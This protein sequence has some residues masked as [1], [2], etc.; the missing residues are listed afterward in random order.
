[1]A[2]AED[3]WTGVE[4]VVAVGDVHGD[5]EALVSVLLSAGLIDSKNNWAGGQAHL[6]QLGD[7]PDRGADSRKA[8]DLLMTLEKQARRAR[9]YVH[10][11]IGNHEAMNVYGD[12]RYVSDGEYAAFAADESAEVQR[13]AA[14]AGHRPGYVEHRRQFSEEG[15]YG[16]WIRGHNAIIRI[17]DT[18]FVH[19]GISEKY[20]GLSIRAINDRVREEL[21]DFSKLRGGI[22]TDPE[23]PLWY[24][25]LAKGD[26]AELG[27]V[28][29]R[30]L[31]S[32]SA[33]RMV[34]GHT[35]TDG[36]IV[37]RF[38]GKVVLAEA[39]ISR[40][41]FVVI[42]GGDAVAGRRPAPLVSGIE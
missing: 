4:R 3:V 1:M 8:M 16:K 32:L 18:A 22:V 26:E 10:V 9:G 38:G 28:V 5:Y 24:R 29:D 34:V 13:E 33:R 37:A 7:V 19:A 39:G 2:R 31:E 20:A 15:R 23:G 12:L 30:V 35:T 17:D 27:P 6:V 41:A 11:L 14:K 42:E 36:A 21:S 25:G 40:Q